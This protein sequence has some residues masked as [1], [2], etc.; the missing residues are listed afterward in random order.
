[1]KKRFSFS[2]INFLA[3]LMALAG[4]LMVVNVVRIQHDKKSLNL[5]DNSRKQVEE[6]QGTLK[7]IRGNIYDRYDQL[8]AGN[9]LVYD[10]KIELQH[11]ASSTDIATTLA[12]IV[13][14]DF[15]DVQRKADT[16]YVAKERDTIDL[17]TTIT[18]D[19]A[20][21][22]QK[23]IDDNNDLAEKGQPRQVDLSGLVMQPHLRRHYPENDVAAN[24][25][26][27]YTFM[28]T[29]AD[30]DN[31]EGYFGIEQYYDKQLQGKEIPFEFSYDPNRAKNYPT[32]PQG[33][34]L[35]LT[36]DLGI[37]TS[38]ETILDN[39]V[40]ST[41]S[42]GGM[43]IIMDPRNGEIFALA[44]NPRIN[45]NE[46]LKINEILPQEILFNPAVNEVYEPGSIHKIVTM[47]IG[48][49][50]GTVKP[51]DNFQD[52]GII[53]VGGE[54][55]QNWDRIGHGLVSME[56]C[57][58]LS[59]NVC[60]ADIAKR[61]G[62]NAYYDYMDRFGFT[63]SSNIDLSTERL[64]PLITPASAEWV[65]GRLGANSFGQGFATTPMQE[66]V[67]LASIANHGEMM[68]PHVLKAYVMNGIRK[69]IEPHSLGRP[70]SVE[71]ADALNKM[72]TESL[73]S[74]ASHAR[75]E[76]YLL[77]GKT[78]TAEISEGELG[79]IN[80]LT[81]ASFVGWGPSDDPR[82]FVY[83]WLKKPKTDIWSSVVAAPVFAEIV[84][85]LVVL[86]DIPPDDIRAKL[87]SKK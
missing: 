81:N 60:M 9:Q 29:E 22:I 35:I 43:I 72:L 76:G 37:Q 18:A 56:K 87:T 42:D 34:D 66:M 6:I 63:R 84:R 54:Y 19:Q 4:I 73:Q 21:Q 5:R 83:L 75:V 40:Q 47:A 38:M 77:A 12:A 64:Y 68:R 51:D 10:L 71:T 41:K 85:N 78:G 17:R 52:T 49:D 33:A 80:H 26:G 79:Y 3:F 61:T 59:L 58:E 62:K 65:D 55:F 1:M 13:G 14:L 48:L 50:T 27:F 28:Q 86:M 23:I 57:L 24:V 69:D 32:L 46:Y 44:A 16:E 2:R 15:T 53:E 82:F 20:N 36:L 8:M 11:V 70:V 25:L 67:A 7:P 39:A 31:G 45:P 74:E 30:Q